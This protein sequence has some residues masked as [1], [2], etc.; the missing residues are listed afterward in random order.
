M[1]LEYIVQM[2]LEYIV[3]MFLE[4]FVYISEECDENR[5]PQQFCS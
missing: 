5:K 2:Y 3:Q 1:Y 4:W